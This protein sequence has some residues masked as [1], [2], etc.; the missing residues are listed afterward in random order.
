MDNKQQR[1]NNSIINAIVNTIN[2]NQISCE[3]S[4]Q[5]SLDEKKRLK[6]KR[7]KM[8]RKIRKKNEKSDVV[9]LDASDS[10][11]GT[12]TNTEVDFSN[13]INLS[14]LNSNMGANRAVLELFEFNIFEEY[15]ALKRLVREEENNDI[16]DM[17]KIA[18]MKIFEYIFN[19]VKDDPI[20]G[21]G[22]YCEANIQ[23]LKDAG[24]MLYDSEGMQG[25]FD[26]LFW[27]FIPDRYRRTID[28]A[29]DGIGEWQG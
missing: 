16:K 19:C 26:D 2:P 23:L 10:I 29:W 18:R 24:K 8:N 28:M 11:H 5:L 13:S 15:D 17:Y 25:M 6:N 27:S 9:D 1:M 14:K 7:K 22:K 20:E 12:M 4:H 21:H 3:S